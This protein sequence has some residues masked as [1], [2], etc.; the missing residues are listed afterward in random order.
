MLPKVD[1]INRRGLRKLLRHIDKDINMFCTRSRGV[2]ADMPT[3]LMPNSRLITKY[4]TKRG[5][6]VKIDKYEG[7]ILVSWN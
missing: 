1:V 5:Y 7:K 6:K 2:I 4:Y 3:N